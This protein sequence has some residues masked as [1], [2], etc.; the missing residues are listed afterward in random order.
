MLGH[1]SSFS[2]FK[3]KLRFLLGIM[4]GIVCVLILSNLTHFDTSPGWVP[5]LEE[6]TF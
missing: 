2:R 5:G 6:L 1:P 3:A 4:N